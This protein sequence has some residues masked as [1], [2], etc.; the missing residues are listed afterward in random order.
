M[1]SFPFQVYFFVQLCSSSQDF[2]WHCLLCGPSANCDS[3]A[4]FKRSRC[5]I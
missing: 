5:T 2:N 1:L 4:C 3:W